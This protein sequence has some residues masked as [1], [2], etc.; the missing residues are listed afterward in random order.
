M[1]IFYKENNICRLVVQNIGYLCKKHEYL[2][3]E[4]W[5][6][7]HLQMRSFPKKSKKRFFSQSSYSL[8]KRNMKYQNIFFQSSWAQIFA[9]AVLED[10][11][12]SYPKLW[13]LKGKWKKTCSFVYPVN[14]YYKYKR[15]WDCGQ[16]ITKKNFSEIIE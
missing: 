12:N 10:L 13:S 5:N 16:I 3:W 2:D 1:H 9:W 11:F 15:K 14:L 8:W 6:F 4:M 7:S